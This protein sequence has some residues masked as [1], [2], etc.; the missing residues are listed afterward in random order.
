MSSRIVSL[1]RRIAAH[2]L[3]LLAAS[4]AV[5]AAGP[6]GASDDNA[7]RPGQVQ[8][9]SA[10]TA[11]RYLVIIGGC[12]DCHTA[13][14]MAQEGNVPESDWLTGSPVGWR[15]PWGTTYPSNLRLLVQSM[16]EDA[17]VE[18]LHTRTARPPMPWMNVRQLSETDARAIHRYIHALGPAGVTMPAAVEPGVEPVTPYFVLEPVHLERMPGV[19]DAGGTGRT[20][21]N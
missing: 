7:A 5:V 6:P 16:S 17:W 8:A 3:F 14:Y 10:V 2:A 15:G 12:N 20:G 4:P 13:G 1:S 21:D 18:M 9:D 11:G 19:T